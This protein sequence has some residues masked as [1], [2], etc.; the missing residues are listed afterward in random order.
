MGVNVNDAL[1][2]IEC[3]E[4]S[5]T[6][7]KKP[8]LQ[9]VTFRLEKGRI[10]GLLGPNG[11]GKSTLLKVCSGL[12]EPSG[13]AVRIFGEPAGVATLGH[14]AVLPDRGK[15]PGWLTAGEWLQFA[16]DLYPDWNEDYAEQL[17]QSLRVNRQSRIAALSRGEEARLQ[18]LTCLARRS[19]LIVLDEPFTGVDMLSREQIASSVVADLADGERT[20][21]IATHDI[22][23]ME[24]LFDCLILLG[25]GRVRSTDDVDDLRQRGLSVESHYRDVFS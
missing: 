16:R 22:R 2:A 6:L 20:F 18:L 25:D 4:V 12:M 23:E 9:D 24:N 1:Y 15:L 3:S 8:I 10:G 17:V 5:V 21:L 13:G 14:M 11:A 19:P 7:K